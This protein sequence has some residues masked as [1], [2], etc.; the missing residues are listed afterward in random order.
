MATSI[1]TSV[2]L[3]SLPLVAEGKVREIYEASNDTLLL[4]TSDR[5]SAYDVILENGVQDKGTVLT[6]LTNHWL[7]TVLP[8]HVPA[9]KHHLVSLNIPRA[10]D[11]SSEQRAIL[12]GRSMI[13][14]K[15]RVF[16]IEA[17]VRGYI[18]GSSWSE[19]KQK[20]TVHGMPQ[21]SGLEQCQA[22]PGGPI[23]TPSTKAPV[24]GKDENIT[25]DHARQIV[26]DKYADKIENL[27]LA[28]YKA[29]HGYALE[30]GIIV[31]DTKFEFG[32][33]EETDEVVLIDEVLTPD[34]SRF[35]P[36]ADYVPGRDQKSFDKQYLRDWL[37][38]EGLKGKE[39]VSMT[40]DVQARTSAKYLEAF[41][42]LTGESLDQ[43]LAKLEN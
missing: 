34:S 17:I 2:G 22:F 19:Y 8:Q 10:L 4:V 15:Y 14:R 16:P 20:G 11:L 5:I 24:G 13:V 39:G 40:G 26:G 35:W 37:T 43:A 1:I 42:R 32:L 7:N 31:A 29:A 30:K 36:A 18:T 9:L 33:D 12:R 25:P 3:K 23:Y 6:L 41:Q 28:I 27:A 21:P 38:G